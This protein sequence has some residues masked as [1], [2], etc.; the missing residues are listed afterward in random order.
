MEICEECRAEAVG[1]QVSWNEKPE[2]HRRRIIDRQY[3]MPDGC[4]SETFPH[5]NRN[6]ACSIA[7]WLMLN[8]N[9]GLLLGDDAAYDTPRWEV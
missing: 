8:L 1:N 9:A 5:S 6:E 2:L 7:D 3:E 4:V